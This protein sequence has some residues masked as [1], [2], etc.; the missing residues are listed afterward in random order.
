MAGHLQSVRVPGYRP[1]LLLFIYGGYC[2]N[3][4]YLPGFQTGRISLKKIEL[5]DNLRRIM[6]KEAPALLS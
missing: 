2:S 3:R 5:F 4:M 1:A 6:F